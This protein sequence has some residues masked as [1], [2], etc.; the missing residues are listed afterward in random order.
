MTHRFRRQW[1]VIGALAAL[2]VLAP[3]L[4]GWHYYPFRDDWSWIGAAATVPGGRWAYYLT[5]QLYAYR[6]ISFWLDTQVLSR[7]WPHLTPLYVGATLAAFAVAWGAQAVARR[8]TGRPMWTMLVVG[9]WWPLL[10]E[11]QAWLVAAAGILPAMGGLIGGTA[12][13]DE[14]MRQSAGRKRWG[15][16]ILAFL[17][18]LAGDLCYEQVWF[19]SLLS[20]G[21]VAYVRRRPIGRSVGTAGSALG[22][23]ALWYAI[24]QAGLEAN[25]KHPNLTLSAV[26]A[27]AQSVGSQIGHLLGPA[28]AQAL[29]LGFTQVVR[30][31][32]WAWASVLFL[33]AVAVW[34]GRSEY[35][36]GQPST[37][38][39]ILTGM[40]V[41]IL[42]ILT[43]YLPWLA[44]SYDW[45][46]ARSLYPAFPG[47]ALILEGLVTGL[48]ASV[49]LTDRVAHAIIGTLF[50]ALLVGVWNLHAQDLWAYRQADRFDS[51]LAQMVYRVFRAEHPSYQAPLAVQTDVMTFV[52][53][54]APYH[55]HIRS[56]WHDPWGVNLMMYDLS[57]GGLDPTVTLWMPSDPAPRKPFPLAVILTQRPVSP[58]LCPS[59]V[60][61]CLVLQYQATAPRPRLLAMRLYRLGS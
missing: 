52:P 19:L 23:T 16:T 41:G 22:V 18:Y 1:L 33:A 12:L 59:H 42:W 50:T 4:A 49:P 32:S 3:T 10:T 15:L 21:L 40:A 38:P 44:T 56:T 46:A 39:A 25:G 17:M 58:S 2:W 47:L 26:I 14:S 34:A 54:D 36:D 55:D 5:Y 60:Q 8:L 30:W 53:W 45:V 6:P 31:P 29:T 37:R 11:A 13:L 48:L 35:L 61:Q 20:A 9:L 27:T 43:A 28:L 24:H 7:W 57:H 51:Q